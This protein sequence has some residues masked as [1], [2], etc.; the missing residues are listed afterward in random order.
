MGLFV[1]VT[2][3][4][5]YGLADDEKTAA[6]V[7]D[8]EAEAFRVAP[9]L[10]SITEAAKTRQVLAIIRAAIVR[11]HEPGMVHQ[12]STPHFS[13]TSDTR[14]Q[15]PRS[16]YYYPSEETSLRGICGT[17]TQA[18]PLGSYPEAEDWP[19]AVRVW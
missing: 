16:G 6:L 7:A 15:L 1:R 4:T 2:D 11:K 9:C 5:P 17:A 19:D 12:Q 10:D 14:Q 18:V 8:F 3:V 13:A